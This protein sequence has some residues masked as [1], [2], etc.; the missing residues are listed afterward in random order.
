MV[1]LPHELEIAQKLATLASEICNGTLHAETEFTRKDYIFLALADKNFATFDAIRILAEKGYS[2]DA[3][4]LVRTLAECTVNAAFVG[5]MTDEIANDYADFSSFM[6][7]KEFEGLRDV[8][9]EAVKDMPKEEV[10]AMRATFESVKKR[11]EKSRSMDW[12]SK[13]LFQRASEID[14]AVSADF[15]LLRVIVNSPWRKACAYVHGTASS[16]TSR[17]TEQDG[18]IVI[19]RKFTEEEAAAALYAANLIMFALLAF[20]DLRLGKKNAKKWLALQREWKRK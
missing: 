15:N 18:G 20:L 16:I 5:N 9:P 19:H 17:V 1:T 8:A 10:E 11:Y 3:F 4:V 6:N 13:N 14:K 2:D 7:W 12:C